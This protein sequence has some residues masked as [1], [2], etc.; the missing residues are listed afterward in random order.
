MT[1]QLNNVKM[2]EKRPDLRAFTWIRPYL[3]R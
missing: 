1:N 3:A 2:K